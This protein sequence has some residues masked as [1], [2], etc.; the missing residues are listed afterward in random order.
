MKSFSIVLGC[1]TLVL[2]SVTSCYYDVEEELYPSSA[3]ETTNVLFSDQVS[4]ILT[5]RCLNCHN[6][7]NAGFFGGGVDLE[8]YT[9][10]KTYVDNGTLLSSITHDGIASFMPK[11]ANNTMLPTCDINQ[12]TAWINAGAPNN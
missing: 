9:N 5:N 7:S 1:V 11:S 2:L 6:T 3:C 8:G 10:V 4:L 12:I